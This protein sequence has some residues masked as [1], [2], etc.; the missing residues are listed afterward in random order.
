MPRTACRALTLFMAF[1]GTGAVLAGEPAAKFSV[2]HIFGDHMVLQRGREVPVWGTAPAGSEVTVKVAG[3]SASA[4]AD[5][6]GKWTVKIGPLE[7]GGPHEMTVAGGGGSATFKDVLVGE[8]WFASGQSNMMTPV[9]FEFEDIAKK[10]L[11]AADRPQIR[12]RRGVWGGKWEVC[13]PESAK[14][15]S[16]LA[17]FFGRDLHEAL[18]VPIGLVAIFQGGSPIET[19]MSKESIVEAA[20]PERKAGVK[21]AGGCWPDIEKLIPYGV[22][23]AI[24]YQGEGGSGV[25]R[26]DLTFEVMLKDW[27]TRWGREDLP[28]LF[29][30]LS[31]PDKGMKP[32]VPGEGGGIHPGVYGTHL[33]QFQCLR[34]PNTGM[35][36]AADYEVSRDSWMGHPKNRVELG[37]RMALLARGM[38]YGEKDKIVWGSPLPESM[39]VQGN[40]VLLKFRH[41]GQGLKAKGNE[42]GEVSGFS[43]GGRYVAARIAAPGAVELTVDKGV[44]G[45]SIQYMPCSTEG[46]LVNSADLPAPIFSVDEKW[47]AEQAR[48]S[49]DKPGEPKG[50]RR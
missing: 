19:F 13:T 39:T 35:I 41:A 36:L 46:N 40:K 1:L 18:K 31:G 45:K 6:E 37:R 17:Y 24:W 26:Y 11:A 48:P 22:A 23:G 50:E 16:G 38:V 15:F 44:S 28:F 4:K 32:T 21:G 3:K 27:R 9:S 5:A 7:A 10:E 42:K 2:A 30:Q 47:F 20:T 29:V 25:N 33:L 12:L 49:G 43:V 8:V 14:S 34:I